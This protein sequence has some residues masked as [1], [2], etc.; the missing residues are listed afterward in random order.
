LGQ[1]FRRFPSNDDHA[2]IAFRW[3]LFL[4]AGNPIK[5]E[6]ACKGSANVYVAKI[7]SSPDGTMFES[8]G[9]VWI[10]AEGNDSNEVDFKGIDNYQILAGDPVTAQIERFLAGPNGSTGRRTETRCSSASE[11]R[12][13]RRR[14]ASPLYCGGR[15]AGRR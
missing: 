14:G 7:F 2:T 1:I 12:R 4:M 3:D 15:L 9:L 6:G 11:R 10:Q 5:S 8:A 13:P